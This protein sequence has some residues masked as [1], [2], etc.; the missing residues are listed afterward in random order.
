[1]KSGKLKETYLKAKLNYKKETISLI[2]MIVAILAASIVSYIFLKQIFIVAFG[3][4]SLLAVAYLSLS[5]PKRVLNKRKKELE[6]EFVHI[7]SYFSIFV[8]N[9]RP[10]YNALEDCLRYSS[11]EMAE[12]I[13]T[14]LEDIDSD[15]SVT[16]YTKFSDNFENLE[17]KQLLVSVYKMSVEGGGE[18]YLRQFDM[19][20]VALSNSNRIQRLENEVSRYSNFNFLPLIASAISM[21]IIAVAVVVLMEE[22]SNVI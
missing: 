17:I 14:L 4:V 9:G 3:A 18:E 10:V 11:E 21:G 2:I 6:V 12:K 13:R 15:K 22:Y 20:F 1:M 16:P 5:K 19:L 8:K 7:F